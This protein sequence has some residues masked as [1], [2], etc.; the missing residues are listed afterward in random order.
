[1]KSQDIVVLLKLVSLHSA[2]FSD[3][4][5]DEFD[6]IYPPDEDEDWLENDYEYELSL[7]HI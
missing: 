2:Y 7:I 1:M 6:V 4:G 5:D 3:C